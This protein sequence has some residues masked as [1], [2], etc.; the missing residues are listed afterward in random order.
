MSSTA[1]STPIIMVSGRI[2]EGDSGN[3][4]LTFQLCREGTL[5]GE[6]LSFI[7]FSCFTCELFIHDGFYKT[8]KTISYHQAFPRK[9]MTRNIL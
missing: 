8:K 6:I 5:M 2:I 9:P 7:G 1:S 4:V 3:G